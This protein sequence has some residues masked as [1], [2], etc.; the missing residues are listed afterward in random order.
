MEKQSNKAIKE[1]SSY[2]LFVILISVLVAAVSYAGSFLWKEPVQTTLLKVVFWNIEYF[3]VFTISLEMF[4]TG[5]LEDK[6]NIW[7]LL[8]G[9]LISFSLLWISTEYLV[10]N[11]WFIG[12]LLIAILIHPYLGA[13]IQVILSISYCLIHDVSMEYFIYYFTFGVLMILLSKFMEKLISVIGVLV[14][15]LATNI[16]FMFIRNDFDTF[17]SSNDRME[18]VSS[19]ILV[20]FCYVVRC[21]LVGQVSIGKRMERQDK[22]EVNSD[23]KDKKKEKDVNE[24]KIDVVKDEL[25]EQL[26]GFSGA[27]Y[28]HSVYIGELSYGAAKTIG[29]NEN[30][31][32]AGGLYHE[33]GRMAGKDYVLEGVELL[34]QQ[35]VSKEVVQVVKEHN[36]RFFAPTS[37]EA[38]IVML[39]DSIVSTVLY[40]KKQHGWDKAQAGDIISSVFV[41]RFEKGILD[42][43]DLSM[44]DI[45]KLKKYYLEALQK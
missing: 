45:V 16:A 6:K 36:I 44:D 20:V 43:S 3:F 1:S 2:F 29:C 26:K 17:L 35:G 31:A 18:L 37:K 9:Y 7:I 11:F 23:L 21:C 38:A 8:V 27:L 33:I 40:L 15:V 25:M 13:G 30:V 14:I 19:V 32:L 22:T 24:Q 28:D 34:K 5:V 42:E 4:R 10:L 39:S 12:S 41:K